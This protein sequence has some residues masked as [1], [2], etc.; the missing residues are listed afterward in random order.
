MLVNGRQEIRNKPTKI[1]CL[2]VGMKVLTWNRKNSVNFDREQFYLNKKNT[3]HCKWANTINLCCTHV[4][5]SEYS[6]KIKICVLYSHGLYQCFDCCCYFHFT[7]HWQ[8][9]FCFDQ[10]A[11]FVLVHVILIWQNARARQKEFMLFPD[12]LRSIDQWCARGVF[13]LK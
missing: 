13:L 12:C 8:I 6:C 4:Y 5:C 7:I 11:D 3:Y 2:Y 1:I 9:S 10:S